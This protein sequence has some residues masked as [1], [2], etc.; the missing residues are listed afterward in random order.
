MKH[1]NGKRSM[2]NRTAHKPNT[3]D[4]IKSRRED[5]NE[6]KLRSQRRQAG[7]LARMGMRR[8]IST[9]YKV[10]GDIT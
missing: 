9:V 10:C 7:R 8:F 6:E 2:I 5:Q 4:D 1:V 3:S